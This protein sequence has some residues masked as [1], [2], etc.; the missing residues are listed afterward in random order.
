MNNVH[1][2]VKSNLTLANEEGSFGSAVTLLTGKVG[3]VWGHILYL[4]WTLKTFIN[5]GL[6]LWGLQCVA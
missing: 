4:H 3:Y 6:C 2:A 5:V 1:N